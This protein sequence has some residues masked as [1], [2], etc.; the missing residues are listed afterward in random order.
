M[1]CSNIFD[2]R[3]LGFVSKNYFIFFFV[4]RR[5]PSTFLFSGLRCGRYDLLYNNLGNAFY[6][7]SPPGYTDHLK[8]LMLAQYFRIYT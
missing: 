5:V 8:R 2:R 4:F 6:Q 7:Q 3:T 1:Q